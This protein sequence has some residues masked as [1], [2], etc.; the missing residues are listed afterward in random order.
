M[1]KSRFRQ[2][3]SLIALLIAINAIIIKVASYFYGGST[4]GMLLLYLNPVL[5]GI[6]FDSRKLL[7]V[8]GAN[9]SDAIFTLV[10]SI[11][12]LRI[13][14]VLLCVFFAYYQPNISILS[15][16]SILVL[17]LLVVQLMSHIGGSFLRSQP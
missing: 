5:I 7:G 16:V 10:V 8:F 11:W 13:V 1:E 9:N 12:L 6:L 15:F 4:S 2:R 14:S 3:A 17:A